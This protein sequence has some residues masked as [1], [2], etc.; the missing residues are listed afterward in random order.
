MTIGIVCE[1]IEPARH[2]ADG[3]LS[4][5]RSRTAMRDGAEER[6]QQIRD[7]VLSIAV[8]VCEQVPIVNT[9][10]CRDVWCAEFRRMMLN[11]HVGWVE[12]IAAFRWDPTGV[13]SNGYW[14]AEQSDDPY[15]VDRLRH[16][17]AQYLYP[18]LAQYGIAFEVWRSLVYDEVGPCYGEMK[19]FPEMSE[20]GEV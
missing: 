9:S 7:V 12:V 16:D 8:E 17:A 11:R 4:A 5:L 18:M 10:V 14:L 20:D 19:R 3:V 1:P 15:V 6:L 2:T 13:A